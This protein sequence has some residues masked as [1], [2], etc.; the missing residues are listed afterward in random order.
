MSQKESW[1]VDGQNLSQ[2]AFDI[3]TYDGLDVTPDLKGEDV[4]IPQS[5]GVLPVTNYFREGHKAV[6]MIVSTADP[7]TGVVPQNI[8]DQRVNF[9]KNLDSLLKIFYRR[10]LLNVVRTLSDGSQRTALCKV[11][12][13]IQPTTLG[14]AS[15]QVSFD[16]MLPYSFWRDVGNTVQTIAIANGAAEVLYFNQFDAATA[17]MSDL[18]YTIQGPLTNPKLTDLETGA[19]VQYTAAAMAAGQTLRLDAGY[20]TIT[21]GGGLAT[22]SLTTITHGGDPRW[23]TAVPSIDGIKIQVDATG[24][25][26]GASLTVT[27]KRAFLR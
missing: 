4:D 13:G 9:D 8:N 27:G 12:S 18:Q 17:P 22:P 19:W 16:L 24:V 11:V 23:L 1:T 10:K 25:A 26:A 5:H 14:L 3:Q 7:A 21:G 6:S 2:F 20:M 15:G